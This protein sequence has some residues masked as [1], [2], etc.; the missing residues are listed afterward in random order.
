VQQLTHIEL[1]INLRTAKARGLTVPATL[2]GRAE[3]VIE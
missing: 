2:L 3:E 1:V